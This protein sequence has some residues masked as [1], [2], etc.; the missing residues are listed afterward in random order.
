[1]SEALLTLPSPQ[2]RGIPEITQEALAVLN[3]MDCSPVTANSGFGEKILLASPS[4]KALSRKLTA[5]GVENL[6]AAW[7]SWQIPYHEAL[8]RP[9]LQTERLTLYLT[10]TFTLDNSEDKRRA[11]GEVHTTKW[12]MG[13]KN[14]IVVP[15]PEAIEVD[16]IDSKLSIST[17]RFFFLV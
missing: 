8:N 5:Y 4:P 14:N 15:V 1:M 3:H 2:E 9:S 16:F 10:Q 13:I 12:R 17:N 11:F 6:Q 7:L